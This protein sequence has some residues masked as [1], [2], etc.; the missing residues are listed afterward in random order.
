MGIEAISGVN[1][2]MSSTVS[3]IMSIGS[4]GLPDDIIKKL[5]EL[6]IDPTTV[7][8]VSE[9]K[10]LIAQAEQTKQ[11]K[12]SSQVQP[13]QQSSPNIDMK[14]LNDDIKVLG[15]KLGINVELINDKQEL[16]DKLDAGVKEFVQGASAQS[17]M[18]DVSVKLKNGTEVKDNPQQMQADF[19]SIKDRIEQLENAKASMFAGQDMLAQ[20]NRMALGI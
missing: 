10:T 4:N 1:S 15:D 6:G 12:Q 9:A 3:G 8:S 2:N 14:Q 11:N 17:N 7:K 16:L 13:Q 18:S 5:K 19:N 20:M